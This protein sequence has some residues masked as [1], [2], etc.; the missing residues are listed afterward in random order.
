MPGRP[1]GDIQVAAKTQRID[2]RC[3]RPLSTAATDARLMIET[4]FLATSEKLWPAARSELW[5][6]RAALSA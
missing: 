5:V 2:R 6:A 1:A 4:T 3:L